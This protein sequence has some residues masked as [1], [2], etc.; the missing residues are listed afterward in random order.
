MSTFAELIS[1]NGNVGVAYTLTVYADL[2]DPPIKRYSTHAIPGST[3]WDPRMLMPGRLQRGQ[4][5]LGDNAPKR[6]RTRTFMRTRLS[7][8]ALAKKTSERACDAQSQWRPPGTELLP[9]NDFGILLA[10]P[11]SSQVCVLVGY[12]STTV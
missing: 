6:S 7:S 9:P 4:H 10:P 5:V 3:D 8:L 2:A 11:I 12:L 1:R